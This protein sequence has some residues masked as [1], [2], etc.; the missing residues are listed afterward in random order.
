ML[1]EISG[2]SQIT[3]PN[4]ILKNIGMNKGDKFEIIERD[5]GIFLCPVVVYPKKKLDRIAKL[6]KEN[7]DNP[8]RTY[9]TVNEMFA[10]MGIDIGAKNV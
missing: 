10:D 6:I 3:L 9:D 4:E 8:S 1:I 2:S 5:G 7:E